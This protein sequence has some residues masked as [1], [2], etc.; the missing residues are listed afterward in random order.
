MTTKTE[1]IS[2]IIKGQLAL[3]GGFHSEE[4]VQRCV[5]AILIGLSLYEDI[6]EE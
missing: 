1:M 6:L 5:R 4:D 3:G 2:N